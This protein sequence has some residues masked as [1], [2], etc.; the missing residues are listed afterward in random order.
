MAMGKGYLK[1]VAFKIE[2]EILEL[3]DAYAQS[4]K[5]FRSEVIRDALIEYLKQR[6]WL[7]RSLVTQK[8]RW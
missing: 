8:I 5:K 7:D 2:P 1:P 6:G 4:N 3:L